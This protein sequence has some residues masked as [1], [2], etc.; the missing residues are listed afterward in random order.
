MERIGRASNLA[1]LAVLF[2]SLTL[3]GLSLAQEESGSIVITA[4]EIRQMQANKMADIL[5]HVP[6]VTAGDSSVGIHGSSKVKVLVDGRPI[7][8]PT[9]SY[10]SINWSL[11]SPEQ[12]ERIEILRG[13]GGVRY[14]QDA[15]GGVILITTRQISSVSGRIKAYGG[16]QDTGFASVNAQGLTGGC[17]PEASGETE[18]TQGYTVNIRLLQPAQ[19]PDYLYHR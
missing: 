8:D 18:T 15:S 19:R 17:G 11:V 16:N 6:G 2:T 4:E 12:V 13:K 7:N 1:C 9:S 14:G 10:G 3:P 5:N